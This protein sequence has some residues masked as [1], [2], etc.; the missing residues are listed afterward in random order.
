MLVYIISTH[1]AAGKVKTEVIYR[2]D[3][4]IYTTRQSAMRGLF[5]LS[6]NF[7]LAQVRILQRT[8]ICEVETVSVVK[9]PKLSKINDK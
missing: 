6:F 5:M 7:F 4:F 9:R 2:T 1:T 3:K 8:T